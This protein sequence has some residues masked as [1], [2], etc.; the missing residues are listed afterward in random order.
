MTCPFSIGD[1]V[2]IKSSE[3]E[4]VGGQYGIVEKIIPASETR[5]PPYFEDYAVCVAVEG[6]EFLLA[7]PP[8]LLHPKTKPSY[9]AWAKKA[10]V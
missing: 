8:R 7:Y 5:S 1:S 10:G 3:V 6:Y 9:S 4:G 2:V